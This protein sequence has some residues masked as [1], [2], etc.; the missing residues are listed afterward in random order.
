MIT[1][2]KYENKNYKALIF[3][4]S[5]LGSYGQIEALKNELDEKN[6]II[7]NLKNH[8]PSNISQNVIFSPYFL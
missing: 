8:R 6:L 1:Q 7:E 4:E 3:N 5:I 2:L